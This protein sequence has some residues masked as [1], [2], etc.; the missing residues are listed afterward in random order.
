MPCLRADSWISTR[1]SY[2]EIGVLRFR[3][4]HVINIVDVRDAVVDGDQR[5][6]DAGSVGLGDV[7]AE[8]PEDVTHDRLEHANAFL[9]QQCAGTGGGVPLTMGLGELESPDLLGAIQERWAAPRRAALRRL[10]QLLGV[11]ARRDVVGGGSQHADE[12]GDDVGVGEL[13]D[14]GDGG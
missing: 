9:I 13:G 7:G 12:L 5:V 10:P 4:A 6:L 1:I 14:G 2:Y 8:L 3:S 11:P